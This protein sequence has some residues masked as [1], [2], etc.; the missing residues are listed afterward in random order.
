MSISVTLFARAVEKLIVGGQSVMISRKFREKLESKFIPDCSMLSNFFRALHA[1]G[2]GLVEAWLE[3][4][5]KYLALLFWAI[6]VF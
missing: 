5:I 3:F 2:S 4:E 1:A 6:I